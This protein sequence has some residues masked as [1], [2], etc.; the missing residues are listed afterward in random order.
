MSEGVVQDLCLVEKILQKRA[1]PDTGAV[2]YLIRWQGKDAQGRPFEDSWEPEQ[3]VLGEELIEE[4]E[5]RQAAK[6]SQRRRSPSR[7]YNNGPPPPFSSPLAAWPGAGFG[8][9]GPSQQQPYYQHHPSSMPQ[10]SHP[11]VP[12]YFAIPGPF[13][14]AGTTPYRGL[15]YQY[16]PMY[17]HSRQPPPFPLA[18]GLSPDQP[19]SDFPKPP[20]RKLPSGLSRSSSGSEKQP[21]DSNQDS[22]DASLQESNAEEGSKTQPD[23]PTVRSRDRTHRYGGRRRSNTTGTSSAIRLL[24]LDFDHEK[25]FFRAVIEK[26]TLVKDQNVRAEMVRFLKDPVHPET[27]LIELKRQREAAGSLFLALDISKGVVKALVIPEWMLEHRRRNNPQ[28]GLVIKD[29][30]VVSAIMD[31]D[32]HGSGLYPAEPTPPTEEPSTEAAQPSKSDGPPSISTPPPQSTNGDVVMEPTELSQGPTSVCGWRDCQQ[33]F[34]NKRELSAHVQRDH[35]MEDATPASNES[36]A[37]L[38]HSPSLAAA[39]DVPMGS[40]PISE[41]ALSESSSLKTVETA[42][43]SL[44]EQIA[45]TKELAMAMDKQI[46]GSRALYSSAIM[47]TKE[48]IR[49]LEAHL[50]WEKKKWNTYHNLKTRMVARESSDQPQEESLQSDS[51]AAEAESN[52]PQ[53][54]PNNSTMEQDQVGKDDS[55]LSPQVPHLEVSKL[56]PPI[57]AQSSNSIRDIQRLLLTAKENLARLE[58]DNTAMYERRRAMDGDL[59]ALEVRYKETVSQVALLKNKEGVTLDEIRDREQNI[60]ECEATMEK[61]QAESRVVVGQLQSMIG[62]LMQPRSQALTSSLNSHPAGTVQEPLPPA[63]SSMLKG[64]T[65]PPAALAASLSASGSSDGSVTATTVV[66]TS[67]IPPSTLAT[68]LPATLERVT[69]Q[70]QDVAASAL[71]SAPRST[72]GVPPRVGGGAG[73]QNGPNDF[74]DM[75]TKSLPGTERYGNRL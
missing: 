71:I 26:S 6:R 14:P 65:L 13:P 22:G 45:K 48:N 54:D 74:I 63:L 56:D 12:P 75:L 62:A 68:T 37:S 67:T 49:R 10:H 32:L 16:P 21:G 33:T 27:W 35:L 9:P 8:E 15:P 30:I 51:T 29:H 61:E 1:D 2:E 23:G 17:G 41:T 55:K 4:Y 60:R 44:S 18:P 66:N 36:M 52:G 34:S 72:A 47:G 3:N 24:N 70:P 69:S 28:E 31:G 39:T 57:E 64:A 19:A 43:Q 25:A 5:R 42:C 38:P 7:T 53:A 20:K 58:K 73:G 40:Q 59:R 50:E 46:R 11:N